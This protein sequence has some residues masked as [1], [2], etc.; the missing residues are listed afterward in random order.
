MLGFSD[1]VLAGTLTAVV[2]SVDAAIDSVDTT[3]WHVL[4]ISPTVVWKGT[5]R[6]PVR[7]LCAWDCLPDFVVGNDYLVY[8]TRRGDEYYTGRCWRN[9]TWAGA[10]FDRCLLPQ[11]VWEGKVPG[12][13]VGV[14]DMVALL[15]SDDPRIAARAAR[16]F[17][18]LD[19]KD[20]VVPLLVAVLL[21]PKSKR[22]QLAAVALTHLGATETV[23]DLTQAYQEGAPTLAAAALTALAAL[24]NNRRRRGDRLRSALRN[25]SPIVRHQAVNLTADEA[26]REDG[27]FSNL[28]AIRLLRDMRRTETDADV[29]LTIDLRLAE[30]TK[31]YD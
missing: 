8:A 28:K 27:A 17:M 1:L 30:L 24:D 2:D 11:P 26:V 7:I 10:V 5:V 29:A 9:N 23:P 13:H 4:T 14:A 6:S 12:P 31:P 21:S 18:W 19:H 15:D 22:P 20:E 25:P 3:Q 16:D